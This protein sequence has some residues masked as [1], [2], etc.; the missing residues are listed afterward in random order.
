VPVPRPGLSSPCCGLVI[1][2]SLWWEVFV[3]FVEIGE[4]FYTFVF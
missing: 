3:Y 2:I 4:F 1:F